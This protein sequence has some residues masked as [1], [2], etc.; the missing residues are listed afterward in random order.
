MDL[1]PT[2]ARIAGAA[3][4]TRP[5]DS[6][7][8]RPLLS[9]EQ[10]AKSP[11][12]SVGLGFYDREQLQAVRSGPWKLYLPLEKKFSKLGRHTAPARLELYNVCHDL[13]E[14]NEV[15]AQQPD[16][17]KRLLSLAENL[18]AEIG[19]VDRVGKGQRPAGHV[20]DPKPLVP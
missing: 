4:P 14:D 8:V 1:L 18:R 6:H 11:W 9:G 15:S 16:V 20:D 13:H 10:G 17:V 5:I 12:D 3:L 19:D 7:D 2:L